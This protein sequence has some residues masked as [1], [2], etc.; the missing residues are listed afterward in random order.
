[1]AKR[2]FLAKRDGEAPGFKT[3]KDRAHIATGDIKVKLMLIY[4]SQNPRALKAKNKKNLP[5]YGNQ[6]TNHC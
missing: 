5:V 2:T 6:I 4:W 1:M 3:A